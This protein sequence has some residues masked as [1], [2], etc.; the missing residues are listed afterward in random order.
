[1][2]GFRL[3]LPITVDYGRINQR[4]G[5]EMI[6]QE[7]RAP[8]GDIVKVEGV[9]LYGSGDKLILA[10]RMSGGINGTV[11]ATGLP[12]FEEGLGLLRF[13]D[14]DFTVDTRNVLVRSANW[15]FHENILATLRSEAFIDLSGQLQTMRSRLETALQ[16][17]MG[18]AGR[19]QGEV[20][21]L[22]PVGIYPVEGGVEVHMVAEGSM[23]VELK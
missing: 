13:A 1:M 12:L 6:G 21:A 14:L 10:M 4:L 8:T 3:A 11:Y 5:Q 19:M 9:Q 18:P 22:R 7:F 20:T 23:W 16:R 15:M 2:E 17:D